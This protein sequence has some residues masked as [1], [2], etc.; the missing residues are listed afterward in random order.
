MTP[1]TNDSTNEETNNVV[2]SVDF[3]ID[4]EYMGFYDFFKKITSTVW[5]HTEVLGSGDKNAYMQMD[6]RVQKLYIFFLKLLVSIDDIV[7]VHWGQIVPG[8]IRNIFVVNAIKRYIEY[9]EVEH[10]FTYKKFI[11]EFIDDPVERRDIFESFMSFE[12]IIALLE[13]SK[14]YVTKPGYKYAM[15]ANLLI[16][17]A[18]LP[19]IFAFVSWTAEKSIDNFNK[20]VPGF[21]QANTMI[22]ADEATHAEFAMMILNKWPALVPPRDEAD[23]ICDE[24]MNFVTVCNKT[25]FEDPVPGINAEILNNVARTKLN[26]LYR[27]VNLSGPKEQRYQVTDTLPG[28]IFGTNLMKKESNFETNATI[29]SRVTPTNWSTVDKDM[30]SI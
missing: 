10:A 23:A 4:P 26:E 24:F 1:S 20:R 19:V 28:Y 2:L 7:V 13:F 3:P 25:T 30:Y 16:E 17:H 29:Y 11:T 21:V 22:M 18:F 14:K 8:E 9:I 15:F 27:R 12:P 5:R 6:P